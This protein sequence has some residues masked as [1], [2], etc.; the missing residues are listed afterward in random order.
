MTKIRKSSFAGDVLKVSFGASSSQ[1]VSILA[2]PLLTR[3]FAP[4]T[5]GLMAVY[6]SIVGVVCVIAGFR[7][8]QA[9]LLPDCDDDAAT[10]CTLSLLITLTVS[11]T[12]ALVLGVFGGPILQ[13]LNAVA[14]KRYIWFIPAAIF[15]GAASQSIVLLKSRTRDFG[16]VSGSRALSSGLS[17]ICQ[18]LCGAARW[19]SAAS[20][21]GSALIGNTSGLVILAT[22]AWRDSHRRIV[23]CFDIGRL[24]SVAR[25]YYKFPL[26]NS[27]SV[28]LNTLSWQLPA[29]LLTRYFGAESAGYFSVGMRVLSVP[30]DVIA[31]SISQVFFQRAAEAKAR[32]C[33]PGIVESA[34]RRLL[35]FGVLPILVLGIIAP[36]LF[37][38]VFGARWREAGVYV[39]LLAPWICVWFVSS[40][41]SVLINVVDKQILGVVF[42]A[43]IFGTRFGA[44]YVGHL[45]NSQYIAL[46]LFSVTGMIVYGW[47]A[48]QLVH[49]SGVHVARLL[50]W[51]SV[52][53]VLALP[54]GGGLLTLK[55]AGASAFVQLGVG[56]LA[57]AIYFVYMVS[58]DTG[59]LQTLPEWLAPHIDRYVNKLTVKGSQKVKLF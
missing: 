16:L 7:Y 31:L 42:N 47:L 29:L 25:R 38:V 58:Q 23:L 56:V 10:I 53:V 5:F 20:L 48:V 40:P 17:N 15:V 11:C 49:A 32:G 4:E 54:V 6:S 55:L 50:R 35:A 30:M 13:F 36:E 37:S 33:L 2:A 21:I 39:Q 3:M 45:L 43:V 18:L 57:L 41:L 22:S 44:L 46:A 59:I 1:L 9:I 28:L 27:W 19:T 52:P 8:E 34:V 12:V 24:R 26:Y 51:I 14:L